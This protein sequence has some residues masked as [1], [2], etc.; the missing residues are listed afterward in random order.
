MAVDSGHIY[1]ANTAG[2]IGRADLNGQNVNNTFVTITAGS[3]PAPSTS[4]PTG[5][6]VDSGHI[7]WADEATVSIGR[8]DLNGQNV[9]QTFIAAVAQAGLGP[10]FVEVDSSHI[11]WTTGGGSSP[12][13]L[14]G[15]I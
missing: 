14:V 15:L 6:A 1:W 7:Y 13:R 12:V 5:V 4:L 3:P 8:A 10:V 9:N 2:Y 11:Y